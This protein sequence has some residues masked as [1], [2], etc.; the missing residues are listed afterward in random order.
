MEL[1]ASQ[2]MERRE[3]QA[4]IQQIKRAVPKG[5]KRRMKEAKEEIARLEADLDQ[6]HRVQSDQQPIVDTCEQ[7]MAEIELSQPHTPSDSQSNKKSKAA[8]RREKKEREEKDRAIRIAQAAKES[9]NGARQTEQTL[10]NSKL[11]HRN[12]DLYDI[13]SDGDCLYKATSHQ[14]S[15]KTKE[16]ALAVSEMRRK[17]ANEMRSNMSE[18]LPFLTTADGDSLDEEGFL[19]YC[20]RLENTHE[21]GGH[22]E[23]KAISALLGY[24]VLIIQADQ[25]ITIENDSNSGDP[26]TIVYHKRLYELGEHYNSVIPRT[27]SES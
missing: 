2:K 9:L 16:P 15:L 4:Q 12:L 10:I 11:S 8:K 18:Y 27:S 13:P 24:P 25:D 22:V 23:I 1:E 3:L 5:D 17:V 26:L 21:W 20:N 19:S 7:L 6:R 14:M